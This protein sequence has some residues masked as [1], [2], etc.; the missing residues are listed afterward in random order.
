MFALAYVRGSGAG[1]EKV[2]S[3]IRSRKAK[4]ARGSGPAC[5]RVLAGGRG[6]QVHARACVCAFVRLLSLKVSQSACQS[7]SLC[8]HVCAREILLACDA[9]VSQSAG[10]SV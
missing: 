1:A 8:V 2:R 5:L 6:V 10:V 9:H 7:F 3:H 4:R